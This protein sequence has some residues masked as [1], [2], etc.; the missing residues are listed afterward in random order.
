MIN[1]DDD[2][3][4]TLADIVETPILT[5]DD[6]LSMIYPFVTKIEVTEHNG[7]TL[8]DD[9]APGQTV[10]VHVSY[11]R[12]MDTTVQPSI[13]YG[14]EDPFTDYMVSGEWKNAR[15]W[16]GT[17]K[18]SAVSTGG[19]M[20]FRAKGGRAASDH[21]LV[22]GT[23]QQR[24]Q[25]IVNA[26]SAQSAVLNATGG[27]GKV[28]LNWAQNDYEL[29]AGYNL[30][31]STSETS[32]FKKLND[33]V[34]TDL[35]YVDTNVASGVTY[36]YYFTMVDTDGTEIADAKSNTVHAAPL[37]NVKPTVTHTPV[38]TAKAGQALTVSTEAS[39]NIAVS[40]VTL[41]YRVK[42]NGGAYIG[43]PMTYNATAKRYSA[44][45]PASAVTSAG[46][47]YYIE[48]RD[49]AGNTATAGSAAIPYV[50]SA[51]SKVTLLTV[52]PN[53]VNVGAAPE[54]MTV[55]GTNFA[56][57]MT[58]KVG[59]VTIEQYT[60]NADGT[61]ISFAMPQLTIG[62]YSVS[63]TKDGDTVT[64][65][66]AVTCQDSASYVQLNAGTGVPGVK[67]ELPLYAVMSGPMYSL[68][69]EIE[70]PSALFTAATAAAADGFNG[71]IQSSWRS[72]VLTISMI[73]AQGV[74]VSNSAP[75]ATVSLTPRALDTAT[76]AQ[77]SLKAAYLNDT[78]VIST[79][80]TVPV[81][82][83]PSYDLTASVTYYQGNAP[84]S[85]VAVSA[86]N[87]SGTTDA[88]GSVKLE[89]INR[90]T[91]DV[92]ASKTGYD[93]AVNLLDVLMLLQGLVGD[94]TLNEYQRLAADVNND[95]KVTEMDAVMI[96]R[97]LVQLEDGYDAGAW[98]FVP[99]TKNMTLSDS[100]NTVSFIAILVGDVDGSWKA[101]Q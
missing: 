16:V 85:G 26:A 25:F 4:G 62:A 100:T 22:C 45:I 94:V 73:H 80:V 28:T 71:Q 20:I 96:L 88:T 36:Y 10:D 56:E 58:V 50:I 11:N 79:P 35:S 37:D 97:K 19:N 24:F 49:A 86:G 68:R 82:I 23:D 59:G 74:T 47:D 38:V 101:A 69:A 30:Y 3:P 31:R 77:L 15:E 83:T 81:A 99:A 55:Y 27:A 64:L 33:T 6:D 44:T 32:G 66:S 14:G 72:G 89:K 40:A 34:L 5:L 43:V 13:T 46:V 17:T 8:V 76:T 21:W 60:V 53:T 12:D 57:G 90:K 63:V 84:V 70:V 1:D 78:S 87:I 91:V 65:P 9:V 54:T 29:L 93:D 7:S 67:L 18:V 52:Y 39:D 98:R 51:E 75:V 95:G 92:T 61:Q 41:Y 42:D 48:A 2:Y